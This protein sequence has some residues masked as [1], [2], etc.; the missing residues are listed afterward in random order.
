[1]KAQSNYII[2]W[3]EFIASCKPTDFSLTLSAQSNYIIKCLE[4]IASCKP[5][6]FSLTL[7]AQRQTRANYTYTARK[8]GNDASLIIGGRFEHLFSF[9]RELLYYIWSKVARYLWGIFL[10]ALVKLPLLKSS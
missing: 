3:F 5:T 2:K 10:C 7:S 9:N 6:Y 8:T 4:F 1:M